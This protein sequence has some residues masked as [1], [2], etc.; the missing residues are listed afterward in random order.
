MN[1]M[2]LGLVLVCG[3]APLL[4]RLHGDDKPKVPTN[5]HGTLY[6]SL[7]IAD[8]DL[9]FDYDTDIVSSYGEDPMQLVLDG[10]KG[11]HENLEDRYDGQS[12][13]T[14]KDEWPAGTY[15]LA[16]TGYGHELDRR[17]FEVKLIPAIDGPGKPYVVRSGL[18][19]L[20]YATHQSTMLHT[21]MLVES[22]TPTTIAQWVIVKDDKVLA[23]SDEELRI[24]ALA[25]GGPLAELKFLE[26][27]LSD[28]QQTDGV[29]V[30]LFANGDTFT[31]AWSYAKPPPHSSYVKLPEL[32]PDP[33]ELAVA[34]KAA[35]DH[36]HF[37]DS[38]F[39][40]TESVACA[41][42]SSRAVSDAM[43]QA[44]D[45]AF[46]ESH[47][48]H[49]VSEKQDEQ[50][51]TRRTRA[52]RDKARAD[53]SEASR[54]AVIAGDRHASSVGRIKAAARK[55]KKGCLVSFGVPRFLP[56]KKL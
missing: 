30:Y 46:D 26:Y 53:Q 42:A 48:I 15:T 22:T 49:R 3:C 39:D 54:Y 29:H 36:Y 37:R 8:G 52:E 4:D 43:N 47:E 13:A 5:P 40:V 51:D 55:F 23:Y 25:F 31:G 16:L 17:Q 56:K 33:K 1:M 35:A 27:S 12:K 32:A 38:D 44:V 14:W 6:D 20:V 21:T 41:A 34:R 7:M 10:P 11:I 50:D 19:P 24:N 9:W 18:P 28:S 2:V 45:S